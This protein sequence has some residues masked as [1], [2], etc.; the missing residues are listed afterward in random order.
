[1]Q[2]FGQKELTHHYGAK[3]DHSQVVEKIMSIVVENDLVESQ[4]L[5]PEKNL[6][7]EM[8]I[9]SISILEIVMEINEQF[10]IK[11]DNDDLPALENI[12]DM[13]TYVL[14]QIKANESK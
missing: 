5:S 10:N 4:G 6:S 8:G 7:Q 2:L 12:N 14:K 3:M 1:M 9:D 13:A 11:I